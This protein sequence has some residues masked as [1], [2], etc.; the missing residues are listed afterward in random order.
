[1]SLNPTPLDREPAPGAVLLSGI[2]G[3]GKSTVAAALAARF[4]ASAHVEVDALQGM[5]VSGGQWPSPTPAP[6]ADRQIFLRARNACLLAGSFAR[7]GFLPVLDDVVVR[8]S[9][10][11]FYRET[12]TSVPLHVVFLAPG[13]MVAWQRNRTRAKVLDIDWSPLDEAMRTELGGEGIWIDN[14]TLTVAETVDAVL[15][16]TGLTPAAHLSSV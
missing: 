16:A 7:A 9:H 2:P 5:I 1:M 6:E 15:A 4:G 12:L 11:D 3:S 13:P 8:S 14:A 10:L